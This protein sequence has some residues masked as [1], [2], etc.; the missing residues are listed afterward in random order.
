MKFEAFLMETVERSRK[1]NIFKF[2]LNGDSHNE[3]FLLLVDGDQ[4]A[5]GRFAVSHHRVSFFLY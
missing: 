3:S 4:V 5:A 2:E 1:Y